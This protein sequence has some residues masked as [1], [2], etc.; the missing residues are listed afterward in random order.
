MRNKLYINIFNLFQWYLGNLLCSLGKHRE[1]YILSALH[2]RAISKKEVGCTLEFRVTNSDVYIWFDA[3][4]ILVRA[5]LSRATG[6]CNAVRSAVSC[7]LPLSARITAATISRHLRRHTIVQPGA[8]YWFM[9]GSVTDC[10]SSIPSTC[11]ITIR[12]NGNDKIIRP[13]AS[14]VFL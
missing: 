8:H 3:F 7:R 11:L 5:R 6:A 14:V 4:R 2:V 10:C 13:S 12:Q 9:T 1:Q